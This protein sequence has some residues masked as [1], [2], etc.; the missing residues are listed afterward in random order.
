LAEAWEVLGVKG[1]CLCLVK[2]HKSHTFLSLLLI[3]LGYKRDIG[4]SLWRD[5]CPSLKCHK[6]WEGIL[7]LELQETGKTTLHDL[8]E[9]LLNTE[10]EEH[11]D[12]MYL[13]KPLS[14][15]AKPIIF[16]Y[17]LSCMM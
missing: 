11:E 14:C 4:W 15:L 10:F 12:G 16:K 8:L 2:W 13:Y 9:I 7:L 6:A 3:I 5:K 17:I 1:K